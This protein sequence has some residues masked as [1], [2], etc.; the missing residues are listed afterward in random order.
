M[1][2]FCI[3][4][5]LHQFHEYLQRKILYLPR[6][7]FLHWRVFFLS[8]CRVVF[9]QPLGKD[10]PASVL[11]SDT[12]LLSIYKCMRAQTLTRAHNHFF[13][14]SALV[15]VEVHIINVCVCISSNLYRNREH[16]FERFHGMVL[17]REHHMN[18]G[19]CR[20]HRT[21]SIIWISVFAHSNSI[22]TS[23]LSL[24]RE[25][26]HKPAAATCCKNSIE[27]PNEKPK[28]KK[29]EFEFENKN[30]DAMQTIPIFIGKNL[31][32][33]IIAF[34]SIQWRAKTKHKIDAHRKKEGKG[35]AWSMVHGQWKTLIECKLISLCWRHYYFGRDCAKNTHATQC[36]N[37][38]QRD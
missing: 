16:W 12:I 15:S 24:Y 6:H 4:L 2:N 38:S 5:P 11:A 25:A 20:N 18:G 22:R 21:Q 23:A 29:N 1:Q 37:G 28:K 34:D 8:L 30:A 3:L 35:R 10:Q 26:Y 9:F 19:Y 17:M 32:V 7:R 13:S 31:N 33:K 14:I 36:T 27:T